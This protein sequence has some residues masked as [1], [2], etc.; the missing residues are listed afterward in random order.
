MLGIPGVIL[1][2][3]VALV[4]KS[5]LATLYGDVPNSEPRRC[6]MRLFRALA[7][8][9]E[10][11]AILCQPAGNFPRAGSLIARKRGDPLHGGVGFRRTKVARAV[12]PSL[13]GEALSA[14]DA[15]QRR[16]QAVFEYTHN[17]SCI[18][19]LDISRAPRGLHCATARGSAPAI[20]WRGCISGTSRFRRCRRTAPTIAWARR[21]Q[22]A[23]ALSLHELAR[24]LAA[25][26]DLA[27]VAV[28]CG[29]VAV[30][31]QSRK[32]GSSRASWRIT[33][34]KRSPSP[35]SA[36]RRAA[37]SVRRKYP[38]F[39]DRPCAQCR[40]ASRRYARARAGAD[41]SVAPGLGK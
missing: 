7:K 15:R 23:I 4:V 36:A 14:F 34:S 11:P 26:P 28:I 30:G 37:A 40:R 41:L 27:D 10:N 1:A 2:V 12:Q 35:S 3:P 6:C 5:T 29:D 22:R 16:R 17:P 20:G 21:M 25:R 9:A 31:H 39:A 38:D 8:S 33:A 24:Y 19:R 32:A 13:A 18:F